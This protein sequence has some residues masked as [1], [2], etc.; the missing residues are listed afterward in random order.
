MNDISA[1]WQINSKAD[2]LSGLRR[3]N[4]LLNGRM[5][6]IFMHEALD[7]HKGI[8][9]S[10]A[11][12]VNTFVC[13]RNRNIDRSVK[14]ISIIRARSDLRA[15]L[16]FGLRFGPS[17]TLLRFFFSTWHASGPRRRSEHPCVGSSVGAIWAV[18]VIIFPLMLNLSGDWVENW[19]LSINKNVS[20]I[21]YFVEAGPACS[22]ADRPAI[23]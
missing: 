8:M 20:H 21:G 7:L 18:K 23:A 6:I 9:I 19:F 1:D 13:R 17:C 5:C 3:Q 2:H 22:G 15:F 12:V 4:M 14:L 11:L 16:T 10:K